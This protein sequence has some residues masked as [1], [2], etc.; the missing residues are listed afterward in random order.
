[1]NNHEKIK[2]PDIFYSI[3]KNFDFLREQLKLYFVAAFCKTNN[4]K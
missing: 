1:M 3:K 4:I 2:Y